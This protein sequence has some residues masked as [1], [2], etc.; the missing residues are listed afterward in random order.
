MT[1]YTV[2]RAWHPENGRRYGIV[3]VRMAD[4][5]QLGP[6][7]DND[8]WGLV[9][10]KDCARTTSFDVLKIIGRHEWFERFDWMN[11]GADPKPWQQAL[12]GMGH[13]TA[14][15]GLH[16]VRSR[17]RIKRLEVMGVPGCGVITVD[18]PNLRIDSATMTRAG[19]P[20]V[21]R[22][23][24][25]GTYG[26]RIGSLTSR[27]HW[28]S[29]KWGSHAQMPPQ[30]LR[31]LAPID[32]SARGELVMLSVGYEISDFT[33]HGDGFGLKVAGSQYTVRR[34]YDSGAFIAGFDPSN[35]VTYPGS[36]YRYLHEARGILLEDGYLYA[37]GTTHPIALLTV[38]GSFDEPA[39]V[40]RTVL[41]RTTEQR[42]VRVTT[43]GRVRFEDCD[44]I[45]WGVD[46]KQAIAFDVGTEVEWLDCRFWES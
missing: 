28:C 11:S 23:H 42:A 5:F 33:H 25:G 32:I 9:N 12:G 3:E 2:S 37:T 16:A 21:E 4:D 35:R 22:W 26:A 17:V 8:M 14:L 41:K 31:R 24:R 1:I 6:D 10:V 43:R 29:D 45:G 15:S 27:D 13:Q 38:D 46:P 20:F 34:F 7:S 30:S 19:W 44:F 40:R 36:E 39:V 18:C